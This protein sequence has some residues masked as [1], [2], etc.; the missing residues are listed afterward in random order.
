MLF[1]QEG[2]LMSVV[3]I[4]GA[5]HGIGKAVAEAFAAHG[6]R[7]RDIQ[8]NSNLLTQTPYAETHR[9]KTVQRLEPQMAENA[10][11][12]PLCRP[13]CRGRGW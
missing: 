5:S 6:H 7:T 10:T 13:H 4:T 12:G 1:A 3:L 9:K 8:N 11:R 2:L